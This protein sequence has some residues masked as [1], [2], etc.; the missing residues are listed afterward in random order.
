MNNAQTFSRASDQ[1][2][3]HRPQYPDELFSYLSEISVE[4]DSA[5]DCATGNGQAAVSCAKYFARVE[6][7]DISAEQIEH[8]IPHPNVHYSVCPAEHTPFADQYFDLITVATAVHWFDQEQ[9]HREVERVLKPGGVLAVWTYGYFKI[10]PELDDVIRRKLLE[11]IDPFWASGNR[12]VLNGYRD[13]SFPFEEIDTPN[14]VLR[15]EWNLEQL[16]AYMRTWSA[17]KRYADELGN[18]PVDGLDTELRTV[19]KEADKIKTVH[20]PLFLRASRK[21]R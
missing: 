3:K 18:D 14:F 17:V 9:F 8:G 10:D 19:W 16:F 12:Q 13:L 4:H 21:S 1:Y 7:T 5:W 15:M 20:M 6:A 11:P 2:A